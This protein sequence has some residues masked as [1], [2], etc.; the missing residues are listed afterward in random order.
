[1]DELRR[2]RKEKKLSQ[3]KL[4][5][6]AGLDPST[7]NQI[8]TGARQPNTR[9]LEKLASVLGVEVSDLFPKAQTPLPL[10]ESKLMDRPEVQAWLRQQGHTDRD[11]FLSW[12]EMQES[13]QDVDDAIADLQGVRDRLVEALKSDDVRHELFGDPAVLREGL[14]GDERLR[15]TFKPGKLARKLTW[16]IRHEYGAR[17]LALVNYSRQL[18]V[19]G[20]ADDYLTYEHPDSEYAQKRHAQMLE[21]RRRILEVNYAKAVA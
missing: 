6:L 14:T 4:A 1:M 3:A 9:T 8:E 10:E 2:L 21:E 17:N 12:A 16:E 15:A 18:F 7:V 13:L 19:E 5:A 11:T 20:E